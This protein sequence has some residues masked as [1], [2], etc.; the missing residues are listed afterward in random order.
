M[1]NEIIYRARIADSMDISD[2]FHQRR[3]NDVTDWI[4]FIQSKYPSQKPQPKQNSKTMHEYFKTIELPRDKNVDKKSV[5]DDE[6]E[7]FT[8]DFDVK[9]LIKS[10]LHPFALNRM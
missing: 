8:S 5:N 6:D 2:D 7:E 10:I 1:Q 3:F 9:E 4:D